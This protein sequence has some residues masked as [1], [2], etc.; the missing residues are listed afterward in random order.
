MAKTSGLQTRLYVGGNDISGDV[1]AISTLHD[2]QNLQ[3]VTGLDKEA[4]ERL[5]L[6]LDGNVSIN[7]WFNSAANRIHAALLSSGK[8]PTADVVVL[9]PLQTSV[10]GVCAMLVAKQASYNVDRAADGSLAVSS[11]FQAN[12]YGIE[13]GDMLTAGKRTDASAATGTSIDGGAQSTAGAVAVAHVF[14]LGSGSVTPVVQ[15][16]SDDS[17]FA[18][19]TGLTFDEVDT[20]PYAER[21]ATSATATI[22]RYVRFDTT[23]TFTAAVVACGFKRG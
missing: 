9:I 20:P 6:L 1:S 18:A 16:S 11:E 21:L 12:G 15:D 23:G 10:D 19:I 17:S 3:D 13:W 5:P 8:V 2:G 7:G 14:S 4:I 22:K